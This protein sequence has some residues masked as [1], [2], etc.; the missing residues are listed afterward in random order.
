MS[1]LFSQ[2]YKENLIFKDVEEG[3][4]N[5]WIK[6]TEE[7]KDSERDESNEK[8]EVKRITTDALYE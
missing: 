8:K 3:F 6:R 5:C 2:H 1:L 7:R 4:Y